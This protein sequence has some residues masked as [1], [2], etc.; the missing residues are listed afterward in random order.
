MNSDN[1]PFQLFFA[2]RF[3]SKIGKMRSTSIPVQVKEVEKIS[4]RGS[5]CQKPAKSRHDGTF[6]RSRRGCSSKF[7]SNSDSAA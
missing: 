2:V 3:R 4:K 1:D 7:I 5:Q 6:L